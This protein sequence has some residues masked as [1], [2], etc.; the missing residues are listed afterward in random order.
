MTATQESL[1]TDNLAIV[2]RVVRRVMRGVSVVHR[3]IGPEKRQ[4]VGA[5]ESRRRLR[6]E[7]AISRRSRTRLSVGGGAG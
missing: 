5:G 2:G 3:R 6:A 4:P 7:R 1:I